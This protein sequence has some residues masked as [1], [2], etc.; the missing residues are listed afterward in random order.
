VAPTPVP[1]GGSAGDLDVFRLGTFRALGDVEL[2]FL[3][4][5]QAAVADR[6]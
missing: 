2:D 1:A 3:P 4:F 6:A 5:L